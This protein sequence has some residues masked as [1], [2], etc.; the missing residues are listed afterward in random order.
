MQLLPRR[1]EVFPPQTR[2][3]ERKISGTTRQLPF[4]Q[5]FERLV[6]DPMRLKRLL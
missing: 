1:V 3:A 2:R 5:T 4:A 6:L